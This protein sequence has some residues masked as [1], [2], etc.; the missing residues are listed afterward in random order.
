M[1]L[2]SVNGPAWNPEA[3]I[4][5]DSGAADGVDT[6]AGLARVHGLELVR[7]AYLLCGDRGLAEDLVQDT[8]THL[9]QRFPR[10]MTVDSPF[11]YARRVLVNAG[12]DRSR[13]ASSR[14][15]PTAFATDGA[16]TGGAVVGDLAPASQEDGAQRVADRD[17]LWQALRELPERQRAVIVLRYYGDLTDAEIAATLGCRRGTVRSLASRG[18]A[19]MRDT[20][21]S[22][23]TH[24]EGGTR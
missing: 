4:P 2:V 16:V 15:L 12:I 14:E 24:P 1:R 13:R 6:V 11:A 8:L 21:R 22:G 10:R 9:Y 5:A 3:V 7:F 18:V 23:T 20:V 17:E 19:A